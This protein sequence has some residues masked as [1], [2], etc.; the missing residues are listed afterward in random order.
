MRN[1]L[2]SI[3]VTIFIPFLCFGAESAKKQVKSGN[4]LYNKNEFNKALESYEKASQELADSDVVNFNLGAA[5]YKLEDYDSAIKYFQKSLLSDDQMLQKKA[6]FNL[7]NSK[8]KYGITKEDSDINSAVDLLEQALHHY[9]RVLDQQIENDDGKYNYEFVQKE[10]VRLKEKLIKQ[11]NQQGD[12]DLPKE[13]SDKQETQG[14]KVAQPKEFQEEESQD[15]SKEEQRAQEQK[16]QEEQQGKTEGEQEQAAKGED[17][18]GNE[19]NQGQMS[20]GQAVMLLD[21]YRQTEEPESLYKQ[22]ISIRGVA[23]PLRDW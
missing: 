3:L 7:G 11:E 9:Q 20:K 19:D 12:C 4:L 8:Y 1:I 23:E 17:S 21:D 22:K 10:L 2:L 15:Q 16:D 18:E 13:D 5:S 6:S 14:S